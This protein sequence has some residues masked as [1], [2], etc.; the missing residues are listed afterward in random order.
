MKVKV[1]NVIRM[2]REVSNGKYILYKIIIDK[3]IDV[4]F[5]IKKNLEKIINNM[6]AENFLKTQQVLYPKDFEVCISV[7]VDTELNVIMVN[8]YIYDGQDLGLHTSTNANVLQGYNSI[9]HFF[10]DTLIWI[11]SMRIANLRAVI[12]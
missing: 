3:D 6:L 12:V 5:S 11:E 1:L 10:F 7:E 8:T 2:P 4:P 9:K